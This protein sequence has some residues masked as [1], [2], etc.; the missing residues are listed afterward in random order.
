[1]AA[2]EL[3]LPVVMV[4]RPPRE[5]GEAVE[6]VTAALDWLVRTRLRSPTEG[7]S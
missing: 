6:T 4:R 1:V 3:G 7:V 5:P 2:R